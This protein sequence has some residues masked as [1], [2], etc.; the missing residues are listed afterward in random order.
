[1]LC[2][3][4]LRLRI[5]AQSH[6]VRPRFLSAFSSLVYLPDRVVRAAQSLSVISLGTSVRKLGVGRRYRARESDS[7]R[8][9][10][11]TQSWVIP[12]HPT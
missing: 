5:F 7:A 8:V 10:K 12:Q 9:S 6:A 4:R 11:W 1:M 2:Q 3:Q